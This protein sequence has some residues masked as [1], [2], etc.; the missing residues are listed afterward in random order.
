[1]RGTRIEKEVE[2]CATILA[3]K[4]KCVN[5][6]QWERERE[7]KRKEGTYMRNAEINML[8]IRC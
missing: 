2:M 8:Y 4:T 1:M 6:K 7:K 3:N 5:S